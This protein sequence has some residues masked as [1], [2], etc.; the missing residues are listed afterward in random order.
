MS[1]DYERAKNFSRR[2]VIV[3]GVQAGLIS[4]LMGR[5]FYLQ[6]LERNHYAMMAED[7]RINLRLLIPPRGHILDRNGVELALNRR[8]FRCI[9][10]PEDM[11]SARISFEAL[12]KILPLSDTELTRIARELDR[13]RASMPVLVR[14]NLTWDDV[15]L[16]EVNTADL[17]GVRIEIGQS[18]HYPFATE[19][20]HVLGYVAAVN[21]EERSGE[22]PLLGLPDFRIGKKG[23]EKYYDEVMRGVAGASQIEVDAYGRV[24][25]ELKREEGKPGQSLQLTLDIELQ[26]KAMEL[27]GNQSGSIVVLN[28]ETGEVL[29]LASAPAF[30]PNVFNEGLSFD[31]WRELSTN[32]KA[33]L[34]NKAISGLY[35][36]GS[37][38]KV[39]TALAG[40]ESGI[41]NADHHVYCSG[42]TELGSS[43]FHCWKRPGHGTLD[44]VGGIRESCDVYFYDVAQKIGIDRIAAMAHRLGLGAETGIDLPGEKEGLIPSRA[45]K[46][47]R[48]RQNWQKGET[49]IAGIGQG[50]ILA[51]PLQLAVLTA[52]L[53]NEGK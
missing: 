2:A 24:M 12:Q 31:D 29:V 18:R 28:V 50:Y 38:F 37:T 4:L 3:G 53:V 45:W 26:K 20:A 5:L 19:A 33:P 7:N 6:I 39:V 27:L 30:D 44:L 35:A 13:R 16:I 43:R 21:Q 8:N 46:L 17:P 41:I 47:R 1:R 15:A 40:L 32:P 51:T 52:R 48:F 9:L 14:D 36:P 49:L 23:I 42:Y 22:D 34:A 25:R 11:G 10:L